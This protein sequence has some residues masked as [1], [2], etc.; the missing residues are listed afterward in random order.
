MA[1]AITPSPTPSFGF[2]SRNT[3]SAPTRSRSVESAVQTHSC[4]S[5][6]SYTH[7]MRPDKVSRELHGAIAEEQRRQAIDAAKKRAVSQHVDYDTFKKMVGGL[8]WGG[9]VWVCCGSAGAHR[10]P[11]LTHC[12]LT[13]AALRTHHTRPPMRHARRCQW[14]TSSPCRP[15]AAR[16]TAVSAIMRPAVAASVLVA[17]RASCA[18]W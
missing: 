10:T 13:A 4:H 9:M 3:E 12:C 15:Q 16:H 11:P 14:P 8:R 5:T 2:C 6:A 1:T 17:S 18:C 7:T